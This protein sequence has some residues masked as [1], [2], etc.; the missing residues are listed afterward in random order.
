MISALRVQGYP[1]RCFSYGDSGYQ[2]SAA[3]QCGNNTID[4]DLKWLQLE[5]QGPQLSI[6]FNR[7]EISKNNSNIERKGRESTG[8]ARRPY[9]YNYF[10]IRQ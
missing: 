7:Q 1:S 5:S 2:I 3:S 9:I 4:V 6:M 8:F 10:G